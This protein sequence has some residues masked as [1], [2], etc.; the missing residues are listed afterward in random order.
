MKCEEF[1]MKQAISLAEKAAENDEVP[2][3]AIVVKDGEIIASAFNFRE[4]GNDATAHAEI[5]A[6]QK[7]CNEVGSWRL[8][9]CDLYVT[10]EPCPMC[11]GAIVNSRIDRVF[12]GAKDARGG[13][14]GSVM[15]LCSYPLFSKPKVI[16]GVCESECTKMLQIFFERK[17]R[18]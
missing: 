12:Y 17:R 7:A 3:G 4:N 6:I 14:L 15:N 2:V 11:A 8:S 1:F 18:E 5:L 13:A 16:G 9:G 10:L